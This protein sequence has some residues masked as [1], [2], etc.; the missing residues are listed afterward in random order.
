MDPGTLALG[1]GVIENNNH[2]Y[3]VLDFGCLKLSAKESFPA[4][5]KKIYDKVSAV[6]ENYKPDEFAIEDLFYGKNVQTA[7][8][9]GHAR[10][11][12]I[13]AAVNHQLPT[14]E[15]SPREIKKSIVGHG[16]AS[17]EQVQ[18]MLQQLL[19]LE[20]PPEPLDASDALAVAVC[21]VHRLG[22]RL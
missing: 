20:K 1:F 4:R 21:H 15:Y 9:M 3:H 7:L 16:A 5:L 13:L 2:V 22:S 18:R 11:V 14:A 17:K 12:A 6:I 19:N 8:K 10:G